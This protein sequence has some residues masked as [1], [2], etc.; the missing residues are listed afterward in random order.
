MRDVQT[1]HP[2]YVTLESEVHLRYMVGPELVRT[3][4][5]PGSS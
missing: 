1:F 5:K 4:V 2:G 3:P